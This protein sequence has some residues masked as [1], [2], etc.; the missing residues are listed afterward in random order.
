MQF[1]AAVT[2]ISLG[3][4]QRLSRNF[5]Y[6]NQSELSNIKREDL[7]RI[8]VQ[9]RHEIYTLQN[10]FL[11]EEDSV[12]SSPFKVM[13]A[14]N[15]LD[16]FEELHRNLLFFDVDTIQSIIPV[17]DRQRR[18]WQQSTEVEFYDERLLQKLET[19]VEQDL[20]S[21]EKSLQTLPDT[22]TT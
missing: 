12:S 19:A 16:R 7:Q 9:I 13:L 15:I 22:S 11:N 8:F 18:F 4:S 10:L 2:A 3:T 20:I 1:A 17:I 14:K 21:L 6:Y 5:R